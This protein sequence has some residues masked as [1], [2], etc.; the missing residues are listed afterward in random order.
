MDVLRGR[1][2]L[3]DAP[4]P[5]RS[6]SPPIERA[7]P[8]CCTPEELLAPHSPRSIRS[9][10]PPTGSTP[11][12]SGWRH[13]EPLLLG[14]TQ[15]SV[16]GRVSRS[17]RNAGNGRQDRLKS[18]LPS[19]LLLAAMPSCPWFLE[20]W[21]H[22]RSRVQF[23]QGKKRLWKTPGRERPVGFKGVGTLPN[24]EKGKTDDH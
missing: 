9:S 13:S 20:E 3:P 17:C 6:S 12:R 2:M 4:W 22:A 18:P 1:E 10:D 5:P 15:S 7:I 23:F 21:R 19:T 16:E 14:T 8:S 11:R 24:G